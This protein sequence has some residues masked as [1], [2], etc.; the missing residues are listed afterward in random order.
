MTDSD[1]NYIKPVE[2]LHSVH[3]LT[4]AQERGEQKRRQKPQRK[5]PQQQ[6][7]PSEDKPPNET[8][9]G[10]TPDQHNDPH[11]IDYCA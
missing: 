10:S 4:P 8:P 6:Q 5:P 2:N 7:Q 9:Q 11:R 1:F 3:S